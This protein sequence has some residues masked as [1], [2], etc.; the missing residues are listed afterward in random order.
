MPVFDWTLL[1][2][3]R[4]LPHPLPFLLPLTTTVPLSFASFPFL[5][6]LTFKGG[7]GHTSQAGLKLAR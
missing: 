1:G 5:V 4:I 6:R 2:S 3:A 7:E